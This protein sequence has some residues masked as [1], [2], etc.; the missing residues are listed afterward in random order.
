[1]GNRKTIAFYTCSNGY[2]HFNRT[3]EIAANLAEDY[4]ITI[5]CE[6]YQIDKF[7]PTL[8]AKFIP[9]TVSN[10]R[11]DKTLSTESIDY[12]QYLDW[13]ETYSRDSNKYDIVISD[14]I[15]GLLKYNPNVL[16]IGSFFWKDV[17]FDKFGKNQLTSLDE[18]LISLHKPYICTNKYVETGSVS[19]YTHKVPFGFGFKEQY[20]KT[21]AR[22]NTVVGIKPSLTYSKDYLDY[23]ENFLIF[24]NKNTSLNTSKEIKEVKNCIYAIRP[25]VGMITHCVENRIPIIALYSDKDSTEIIEL[26]T[27]VEELGIGIKLDINKQFN[28]NKLSSIKDNA[29]YNKVSFELNGYIAISEFIR[30]E[31]RSNRLRY[32]RNR[33]NTSI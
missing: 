24:I 21:V 26:A 25:G 15:V 6:Q 27:K 9:Y 29:I 30:N 3:L 4:N 5:Y 11:W 28:L 18:E 17:F 8:R 16:L 12:R 10:I 20:N 14:N 13:I 2:G 1:M 31:N 32:G 19:R 22:I 7:N 23:Q 33:H